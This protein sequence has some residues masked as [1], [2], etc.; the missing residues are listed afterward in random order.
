MK[1][2]PLAI[3]M[4]SLL[5]SSSV[6]SS[7]YF[8]QDFNV[9]LDVPSSIDVSAFKQDV[10][11]LSMEGLNN[12]EGELIGSMSI[13]TSAT[14]CSST[15]T[16]DNGFKLVGPSGSLPYVLDY[17]ATENGSEFFSTGSEVVTQFSSNNTSSQSVGCGLGD[18]KMRLSG[19]GSDDITSSSGN[20]LAGAYNDIIHVEVRTNL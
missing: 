11:S 2:L 15:I 1:K 16:T 9:S 7:Q 20:M 6:F 10:I 8:N 3:A 5:A 17:I 19:A 13:K 18:L 12:K 4:V 14:T